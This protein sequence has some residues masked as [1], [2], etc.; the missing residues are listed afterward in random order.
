MLR[1]TME[2]S[3]R[4]RTPTV[5]GLTEPQAR[6]L[7]EVRAVGR[8]VYGGRQDFA[9]SYL[10]SL[11]LVEVDRDYEQTRDHALRLTVWPANVPI[12]PLCVQYRCTKCKRDFNDSDHFY[13]KCHDLDD[14]EPYWPDGTIAVLTQDEIC[15][16][17]NQAVAD[18]IE[19][20]RAE[21]G[22]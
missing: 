10:E 16:S 2:K 12:C 19:A 20:H 13:K 4:S 11:H 6:I 18:M 15:R 14:Y 5:K 17:C 3:K 8:R 21:G 7:F 22:Y 9:V 1:L